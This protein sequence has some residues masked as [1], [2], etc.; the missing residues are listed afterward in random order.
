MKF[1]RSLSY[2]ALFTGICALS[3]TGIFV[4]WA[5]APG[6]VTAAYRMGISA[7]VL[8]PFF[9]KKETSRPSRNQGWLLPI[10]LGGA[11]VAGDHG[12]LNTAVGL[13]RIANTTLLNNMAPLWVAL[14]ALLIWKEKLNRTFWLGLMAALVGAIVILGTDLLRHPQLGLGDG[15]ALVSSF[16]YA[17]Y[18]LNTQHSREKIS[19]LRYLFMVN[20]V[21]SVLLFAFNLISGTPIT[22]YPLR[23]YLVFLA[24]GIFSHSIGYFCITYALGHLP[25]SIVA[26]TMIAQL[27]LTSLLAIPLAGESLSLP[28]ILGGLAVLAG[29]FLVNQSNRREAQIDGVPATNP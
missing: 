5:Q 10:L 26:P 19:T 14:F 24:I 3:M 16:F 7:L 28:Q 20:I 13:T 22:G 8:L 9:L 25:A 21:S 4:R 18:F 27:L 17:A 1:K 11:F 29:I 2:L 6:T 15:L 23:T 12:F